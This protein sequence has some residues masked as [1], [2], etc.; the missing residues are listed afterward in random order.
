MRR[1]YGSSKN[2]F[3]VLGGL[4][5]SITIDAVVF[6]R[7]LTRI[8]CNTIHTNCAEGLTKLFLKV[9][10]ILFSN[11]TVIKFNGKVS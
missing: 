9:L 6:M 1:L 2:W 11:L 3:K 4:T 7:S 5:V 10:D 8:L